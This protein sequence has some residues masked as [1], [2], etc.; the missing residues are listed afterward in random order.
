MTYATS[1]INFIK[2][3]DKL[4]IFQDK[5]NKKHETITTTKH[6]TI[7]L[8]KKENS[9]DYRAECNDNAKK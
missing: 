6:T 9:I 4:S 2:F 8:F 7:N 5:N 3:Q 1:N